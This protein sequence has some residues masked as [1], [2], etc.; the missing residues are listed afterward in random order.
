MSSM[1]NDLWR[2][3]AAAPKDGY[4]HGFDLADNTLLNEALAKVCEVTERKGPGE[5]SA[6]ICGTPSVFHS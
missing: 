1:A 6:G 3:M 5:M 4:L 2:T